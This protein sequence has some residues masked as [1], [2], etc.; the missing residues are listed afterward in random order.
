MAPFPLVLSDFLGHWG[1]YL[2][3]LLIGFGFGFVLEMSGFGNSKKL[4]AQFYLHDMT[5][6]KVMFS[7]IVVAMTLIFLASGLGLLDYNLVWVNTTYLWPGIVG[8]LIMGVGFIVG[9]FCP[10]TSLV[11]AATAKLDGV[12]FVLGVLFGIFVFGE[13]VD[14]FE[15]FFNSSYKGRYT[16][17]EMLGADTGIV[18]LGI[19]LMALAVF[20]GAEQVENL[21]SKE[22]SKQAPRWRYGAAGVLAMAAFGVA[23]IGQPTTEDRWNYI[24]DDKLKELANREVQID[25]GEV[26]SLVHNDK[27]NIVMIDVRNEADYNLFHLLDAQ[28][29]PLSQIPGAALDLQDITANTVVV[30]M[31]NDEAA[32]TDAWK[33]L[34][35][36]SVPNVYILEGGI[37]HW[38]EVI[39]DDTFKTE[40]PLITAGDDQL[41]YAFTEALGARYAAAQPSLDRRE[42]EFTAKVKLKTRQGP[43]GG[44]CG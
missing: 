37:N 12:F 3:Y 31:S 14:Q 41:R 19:I 25:P 22:K 44:G 26:L 43:A 30:L 40:H 28:N 20:F 34:V 1:Q 4:A 29:V 17:P 33:T 8:G 6:L 15:G 21:F 36:E 32:A 42:L 2:I 10:G 13:T 16:I 18:V 39:A 27:L 9:G 35:A 5:V 23:V 7:A 11:A 38:I 24:K